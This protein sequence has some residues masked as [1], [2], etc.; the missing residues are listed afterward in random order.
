M[1]ETFTHIAA[2]GF[3]K[4]SKPR[5]N[6]ANFGDGYSQR[7]IGSINHQEDS[8]DL[9]FVHRSLVDS[10]AIISF[11]ESHKGAT[12]FLWTPPGESTEY[13]VICTEWSIEYSSPISRIISCKFTRVYDL[14]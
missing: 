8:W 2:T 5:V 13:K 10:A 12:S 11:F 9:K 6:V 7:I 3:N 14:D 4:T 1:A